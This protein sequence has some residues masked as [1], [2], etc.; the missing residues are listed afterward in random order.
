MSPLLLIDGKLWYT[1][2]EGGIRRVYTAWDKTLWVYIKGIKHCIGYRNHM[3]VNR[4]TVI[5]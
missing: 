4:A 1:L 2:S 5:L 3:G